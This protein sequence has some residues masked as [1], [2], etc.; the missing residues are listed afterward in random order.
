MS[1]R[2]P[3]RWRKKN[4]R[5]VVRVVKA[6]LDWCCCIRSA[7]PL[8]LTTRLN[9]RK[10]IR[11]RSKVIAATIWYIKGNSSFGSETPRSFQV[12]QL[13]QLYWARSI[14][15]EQVFFWQRLAG[16]PLVSKRWTVLSYPHKCLA[17]ILSKTWKSTKEKMLLQSLF[18]RYRER[19][20]DGLQNS[21][22]LTFN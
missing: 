19:M 2:W 15:F 7:S 11:S 18:R 3:L 10:I 21:C 17:R 1:R 22:H 16:K 6:L 8:H 20:N 4:K 14:I 9:K 13:V 5:Q 12:S